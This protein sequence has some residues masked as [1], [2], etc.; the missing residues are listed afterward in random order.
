MYPATKYT[1]NA[2]IDQLSLSVPPLK[3][4]EGLSDLVLTKPLFRESTLVD[5]V[6]IRH[7][8]GAGQ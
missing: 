5:L 4:W 8:G 1:M 6:E 3:A 7:A 2:G